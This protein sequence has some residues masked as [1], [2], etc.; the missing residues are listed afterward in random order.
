MSTSSMSISSI[1]SAWSS[2]LRRV[3]STSLKLP[4]NGKREG[5]DRALH[6]LEHI[7]PQQVDQTFFAIRLAEEAFAAPYLGAVFLV[8]GGL[9]VRQHI[10]QRCIGRQ[11]EAADLVVD[12]ADG[13]ELARPDPRRP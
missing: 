8:V 13:L 10:A 9:L 5:R 11:V 4:L 12:V 6:A 1:S 2:I 3:A 7:D